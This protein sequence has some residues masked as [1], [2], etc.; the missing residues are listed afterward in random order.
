VKLAIDDFGVGY[1]S[2]NYLARFQVDILKIDQ[3]FINRMDRDAG[4]LAIVQAVT[5][6]A[7]KLGIGVTAE[8]I[9]SPDQLL[10]V[11]NVHCDRGQGFYFSRALPVEE[12]DELLDEPSAWQQRQAG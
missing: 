1:S 4:T 8:G 6:L 2:L 11:R 12:L 9:E 5:L 10:G 3:S 7:Q